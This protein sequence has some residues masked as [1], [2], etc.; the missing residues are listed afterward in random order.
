MSFVLNKIITLIL[1]PLFLSPYLPFIHVAKLFSLPQELVSLSE[2]AIGSEEDPVF[3]TAH[4]GVQAVAPQNTIPAYEKAVELGFYSAECDIQLTKDKQWVLNHNSTT[5]SMF[6]EIAE[7]SEYTVAELKEFTYKSGAN[8]W[9]YE[10]LR[11][12]TLEE[13]LDVFVG[14]NTRPQIEIKTEN[15]DMLYTIVDAVKAKGLEEQA[16]IISFSYEQLQAI[17]ELGSGIELWYLVDEITPENIAKAQALTS[18][19]WLSPNFEA[20]TQESI[21]LAID[22]GVGCSFWTVND[23]EDAKMLYDMGIRYIETDIFCN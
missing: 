11:I 6:C 13:Y 18:E 9:A 3:L 22:A 8:F 4:R 17:D 15:T 23:L 14:S 19:T 20:N 10:N 12:P 2:N 1:V 21:Q 7:I 5:D 16:I